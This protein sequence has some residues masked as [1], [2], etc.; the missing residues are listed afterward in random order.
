MRK[1]RERD[2]GFYVIIEPFSDAV[3]HGS[4]ISASDVIEFCRDFK[5]QCT[6]SSL[7]QRSQWQSSQPA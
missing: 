2:G 7:M 5:V 4:L 1:S 3:L 6:P